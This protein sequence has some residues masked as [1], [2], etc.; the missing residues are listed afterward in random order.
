MGIFFKPQ[1][2]V[3]KISI[4]EYEISI[5]REEFLKII[6]ENEQWGNNDYW[7]F[8]Y[9]EAAFSVSVD[10]NNYL[11]NCGCVE[12]LAELISNLD[13]TNK[14][15]VYQQFYIYDELWSKECGSSKS[16]NAFEVE[17]VNCDCPVKIREFYGDGHFIQYKDEEFIK[18]NSEY[19]STVVLEDDREIEQEIVVKK[20]H[21]HNSIDHPADL[22]DAGSYAQLTSSSSKV[23]IIEE[24]EEEEE[25]YGSYDFGL[26]YVRE[27]N[28]RRNCSWDD[29]K[30]GDNKPFKC[31]EFMLYYCRLDELD[32]G[33]F[34]DDNDWPKDKEGLFK[35]MYDGK[36]DYKDY[37]VNFETPESNI[38]VDIRTADEFEW[39]ENNEC[40]FI[41][42]KDITFKFFETNEEALQSYR[43]LIDKFKEEVNAKVEEEPVNE[44]DENVYGP[45]LSI[46]S[47]VGCDLDWTN[48][49]NKDCCAYRLDLREY[50]ANVINQEGQFILLNQNLVKPI[51]EPRK[52]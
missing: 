20:L 1:N 41:N 32:C 22:F 31:Q 16:T 39:D 46:F 17:F 10:N 8:D 49:E 35:L 30:Y 3:I 27:W 52:S 26:I 23:E 18:S 33:Y 15:V 13:K 50:N 29:A 28:Y 14:Y 45:Y 36:I 38:F 44:K 47:V 51:Q 12:S 11:I 6:G 25:D 24:E 43:K 48:E 42:E 2:K 5:Q 19:F 37:S 40:D 9:A 4:G 34:L 21:N 7:D